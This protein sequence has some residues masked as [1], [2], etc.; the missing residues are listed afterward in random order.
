MR[1]ENPSRNLEFAAG[2]TPSSP[3]PLPRSTGGEGRVFGA[4]QSCSSRL[5]NAIGWIVLIGGFAA[6]Q[7]LEPYYFTQDDVL[8]GELPGVRHELRDLWAGTFP[9]WNPYVFMGAP[10]ALMGM[11]SVT[12]PPRVLAYALARHIWQGIGADRLDDIERGA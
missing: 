12:Y 3:T 10:V 2:S 5:W 1:G 4:R 7:C 11:S 6:L 9:D 8:I